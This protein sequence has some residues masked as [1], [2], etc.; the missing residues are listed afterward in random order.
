MPK[1]KSV[2]YDEVVSDIL[3]FVNKAD[4]VSDDD[5]ERFGWRDR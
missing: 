5:L 4:D 3:R 1:R 2:P